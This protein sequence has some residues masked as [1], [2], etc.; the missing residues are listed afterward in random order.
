MYKNTSF[1]IL[2]DSQRLLH[3]IL[4]VDSFVLFHSIQNFYFDTYSGCKVLSDYRLVKILLVFFCLYWITRRCFVVLAQMKQKKCN[5]SQSHY[6]IHRRFHFA[7]GIT[8]NV[9]LK[10]TVTHWKLYKSNAIPK[11][12]DELS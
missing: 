1:R 5:H 9:K 10:S 12:I 6:K 3:K 2:Y 4:H 11:Y 8:P 7:N